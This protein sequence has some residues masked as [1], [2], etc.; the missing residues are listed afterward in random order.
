MKPKLPKG[1]RLLKV[2]E[3]RPKGYMH[4]HHGRWAD[5]ATGTMFIG[6]I[7]S[8]DDMDAHG[9]YIAP[10]RTAKRRKKK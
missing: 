2:G 1:Y 7:I 3:K 5:G 6:K 8:D 4:W 10:K 9:P